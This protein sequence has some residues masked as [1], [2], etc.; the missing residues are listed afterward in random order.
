MQASTWHYINLYLFWSFQCIWYLIHAGGLYPI[1]CCRHSQSQNPTLLQSV[2]GHCVNQLCT[3][4]P[5]SIGESRNPKSLS[6]HSSLGPPRLT[7]AI[8][9]PSSPHPHPLTPGGWSLT[10]L[11]LLH[12]P[13]MYI[14]LLFPRG[15]VMETV[16]CPTWVWGHCGWVLYESVTSVISKSY[17]TDHKQLVE[18]KGCMWVAWNPWYGHLDSAGW[19]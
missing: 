3:A 5:L 19:D 15:A 14:Q 6:N 1:S 4:S 18:Q 13:G 11:W 17:C 7:Q 9:W 10:A 2:C 16:L 8:A 12:T